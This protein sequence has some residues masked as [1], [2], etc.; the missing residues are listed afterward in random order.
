MDKKDFPQIFEEMRE[1]FIRYPYDRE[2]HINHVFLLKMH[3]L[4]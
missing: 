4:L 2:R 3:E 1:K